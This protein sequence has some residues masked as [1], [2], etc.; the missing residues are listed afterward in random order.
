MRLK[1]YISLSLFGLIV[2]FLTDTFLSEKW[3]E[4]RKNRHRCEAE[5]R[6]LSINL[7]GAISAKYRDSGNHNAQTIEINS[8]N[9]NIR[10]TFLLNET[11]GF[12]NAVSVGDSLYK[13]PGTLEIFIIRNGVRKMHQLRYDC[14]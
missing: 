8:I 3:N 5:Q 13:E 1:V 2:Y 12:F 7:N 11:G 6:G 9:G 4:E 14:D 10:S